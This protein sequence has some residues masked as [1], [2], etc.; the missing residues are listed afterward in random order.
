MSQQQTV[1]RVQ[2]NIPHAT[3]SGETQFTTLDLYSDIPIKINKSFAELQDIGSKNSDYSIGLS[4]PGSK[5]NNRFFELFFNVDSQSLY[6]N[7]TE[8]VECI[9]LISDQAY[10]TGFMKLNKVS[11]MNSKVEYDV[12]LFSTI[13]NLFGDIGN[14]LLKDLNFDD[15]EYTF[16]HT[17]DFYDSIADP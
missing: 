13:G 9:V 5:K 10:F 6:F 16:N 8:K 14:N 3:I 7:A 4:L 11:V 1:L 2:T 15:P 17:F 12:T